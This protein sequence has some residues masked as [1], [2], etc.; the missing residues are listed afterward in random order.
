MG[1]GAACS[2]AFL[3]ACVAGHGITPAAGFHSFH[4]RLALPAEARLR[5]FFPATRAHE[6]GIPRSVPPIVLAKHFRAQLRCAPRDWCALS[7]GLEEVR[8]GKQRLLSAVAK[9]GINDVMSAARQLEEIAPANEA[10]RDL[11]GGE[12]SLVFSTQTDSTLG[13]PGAE[14]DV[15]NAINAAL[16]RFFFK[17]APFLAGGQERNAMPSVPGVVTQNEQ[18]RPSSRKCA[19]PGA[20]CS[21]NS[22]VVASCSLQIVDLASKSVDNRVFLK[23]GRGGPRVDIRVVGDLLGEDALDL[24]VT[25]TSFSIGVAP[26]PAVQRVSVCPCCSR[27]PGV[28]QRGR[29][30]AGSR[31][32]ARMGES[33]R[34]A[35]VALGCAQVCV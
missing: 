8:A 35:L 6:G 10:S 18:V 3:L 25:F 19:G 4:T 26:L 29:P 20:E 11:V 5:Q 24:G 32:S 21:T 9:G 33:A 17:F 15:V 12:W 30:L 7:I 22:A 2:L 31:E 34:A 14:D 23:L 28:V 16:Y 13:G 1:Q 27:P